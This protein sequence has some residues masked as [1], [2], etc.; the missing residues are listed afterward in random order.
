MP[1]DPRD[2][3]EVLTRLPLQPKIEMRSGRPFE[4]GIGAVDPDYFKDA[5]IVNGVLEKHED[6]RLMAVKRP[7]YQTRFDLRP[8]DEAKGIFHYRGS[9][10]VNDLNFIPKDFFFAA[11]DTELL[12]NPAIAAQTGEVWTSLV[13][14]GWPSTTG[15]FT[16]DVQFANFLSVIWAVV[17][18]RGGTTQVWR[19]ADN[20]TT[21]VLQTSTPGWVGRNDF[22]VLATSAHMYIMGGTDAAGTRLN[23][24]WRSTN[25]ITWTQQTAAAPWSAR[26]SFGAT[27]RSTSLFI[28]GGN[29]ASGAVNDVWTSTDGASWTNQVA[30][31]QWSARETLAMATAFSN[32]LWVIGGQQTGV[33]VPDVWVSTD[34]GVSWQLTT[35][36]IGDVSLSFAAAWDVSHTEPWLYVMGGSDF[37]RSRDGVEWQTFTNTSSF[38]P[39]PEQGATLSSPIGILLSARNTNRDQVI[40]GV[41]SRNPLDGWFH[42][43]WPNGFDIRVEGGFD[44]EAVTFEPIPIDPTELRDRSNDELEGVFIKSKFDAYFYNTKY[45][46][47]QKVTSENYPRETVDGAAWLDGR[48]Y[49]LTP[50]G[51]I[52]GSAINDPLAWSALNFVSAI[53]HPDRGMAIIRRHNYILAWGTDS[54][55][56]FYDSGELAGAVGSTLRRVDSAA[57]D[58]GCLHAGGVQRL[59]GNVIWIGMAD[60]SRERGVYVLDGYQPRKVSTPFIDRILEASDFDCAWSATLVANGHRLYMFAMCCIVATLVYDMDMEAWYI[61]N[62][63]ETQRSR[64]TAPAV[65]TAAIDAAS[66]LVEV[67]MVD[68]NASFAIA[69]MAVG[70]PFRMTGATQAEYNGFFNV[71][72][73]L[74]STSFT[75]LL[76]TS[77]LPTTPAT[78]TPITEYYINRGSTDFQACLTA[79]MPTFSNPAPFST[80]F[81]ATRQFALHIAT[82]SIVEI[83]FD[84]TADSYRGAND[85][86]SSTGDAKD[87]YINFWVRTPRADFGNNLAKFVARAEVIGDNVG[88]QVHVRYS[89]DDYQTFSPYRAVNMAAQRPRISRQGRTRRRAY[90]IRHVDP[91]ATMRLEGLELFL[92]AGNTS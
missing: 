3:S 64:T 47:L 25:G 4:F 40:T 72:R 92:K 39:T 71:A 50:E 9:P 52:Y 83:R 45:K 14:P 33:D 89:D 65:L 16:S 34:L 86:E 59:G 32:R 60:K 28:A 1:R 5:A 41:K 26:H 10:A 44:V 67:T 68:T 66:G 49:V 62:T 43:L 30:A 35:P 12:I 56:W 29:T 15:G 53:R 17:S 48:M 38:A 23:D 74:S 18:N 36:S 78:G 63:E 7:G 37:A 82:P 20:G 2:Q 13:T 54:M 58:F 11:V 75:Y 57:G 69:D 91:T 6:G 73:I 84:Y 46:R 61:W 76:T 87:H 80:S 42:D 90:D 8:S 55:E 24:V 31:A 21:W 77:T 81:T 51:R 19:S 79:P 27:V 70:D 85:V 88:T 22:R